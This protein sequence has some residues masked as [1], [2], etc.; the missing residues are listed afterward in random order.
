MRY[1]KVYLNFP[2]NINGYVR[3]GYS[4]KGMRLSI[5]L[6][7]KS[8]A[9]NLSHLLMMVGVENENRIEIMS[10]GCDFQSDLMVANVTFDKFNFGWWM[11]IDMF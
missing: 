6:D 8:L 10:V 7:G 3:F 4:Y 9:E 1:V 5:G 11:I 2:E